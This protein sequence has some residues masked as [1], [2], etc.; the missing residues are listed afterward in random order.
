MKHE[1]IL[2]FAFGV[3]AALLITLIVAGYLG[4][5]PWVGVRQPHDLPAEPTADNIYYIR[6][7]SYPKTLWDWLELLIVPVALAV[8][9]YL[10]STHQRQHAEQ[11]ANERANLDQSLSENRAQARTLQQYLDRMTDLMLNAG[12]CDTE[13]SDEVLQ[14]A[15]IRTLT[16]LRRLDSPRIRYVLQFLHDTGLITGTETSIDL[17][18]ADLR[19][20]HCKNIELPHV[21]LSRTQMSEIVLTGATLFHACLCG[22]KL[23]KADL[24]AS[25]LENAAL[26]EAQLVKA[27]LRHV[28]LVN[29]N[30]AK[31]D[32]K[33]ANL[34]Y[35][36]LQGADVTAANLQ[37]TNLDGANLDGAQ[38]DDQTKWPEEFE[39]P[40]TAELLN[41]VR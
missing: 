8:V 30:L 24:H 29:A 36:R 3:G 13:P 4:E 7:I 26:V 15:R 28:S 40:K 37:E 27:D 22:T 16:V 1:K 31:A 19:S 18:N 14:I 20:A 32:L 17:E 39:P 35:A 41:G 21:N 11:M 10:F 6:R 38:F 23:N 9:G 12:L 5:W 33:E 25:N 2:W 34:Q